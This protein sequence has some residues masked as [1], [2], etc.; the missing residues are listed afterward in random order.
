MALLSVSDLHLVQLVEHKFLFRRHTVQPKTV[1]A[2]LSK[3]KKMSQKL[4]ENL[5]VGVP[6]NAGLLEFKPH[7]TYVRKGFWCNV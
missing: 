4:N 3:G 5:G 6:H 2:E 1:L 7:I